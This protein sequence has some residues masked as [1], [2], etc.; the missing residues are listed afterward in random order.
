MSKRTDIHRPSAEEFDP[1]A[2]ECVGVFDLHP[3][4]FLYDVVFD[5]AG[6]RQPRRMVV[7]NSFLEK[8]FHFSGV[9]G[10]GACDHCGASLRYCALLIHPT[11]KGMVWVGETCLANRFEG[12]TKAEFRY[13][14]QQ[15]RLNTERK[16]REERIGQILGK[17]SE[18]VRAA[19]DWA[20]TCPRRDFEADGIPEGWTRGR[21]TAEGIADQIGRYKKPLSEKQEKF[22]V[23]LYSR[24]LTAETRKMGERMKYE[25]GEI[26]GV[27]SGRVEVVGEILAVKLVE[28]DFGSVYKMTVKDDRGFKV[29]GTVPSTLPNSERGARVRFTARLEPANNDPLFGFFSRPTKAANV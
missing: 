11:S 7:V 9:H 8:G 23:D 2:Y 12:L 24:F 15:A 22:L 14:R 10:L 26:E 1:E 25:A 3:D 20:N 5:A 17:M 21:M 27:P 16:T 28:N 29:Y 19:Y 18:E 6:T 4:A 13:L